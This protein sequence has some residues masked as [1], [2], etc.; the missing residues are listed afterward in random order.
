[1]V[2]TFLIIEPLLSRIL[3]GLLLVMGLVIIR[4]ILRSKSLSSGQRNVKVILNT[5]LFL[6][7]ILFLFQPGWPE[8]RDGEP[9]LVHDT[10]IP[11]EV[12]D[13]VQTA[14]K[15]KRLVSY[16]E[17]R[18]KFREYPDHRLLFFG[19]QAEPQLLSNLAGKEVQW[20]PYFAQD[21]L[22]ELE[23]QGVL[24]KGEKQTVTGKISLSRPGKI[25]LVYGG[26]TLD[27]L[28]LEK[29]FN[30]FRLSFPVFAEG[31]NTVSLQI[32]DQPLQ[33]ITF[34]ARPVQP[35]AITML[36][37][38]PDFES[39]ILAEWL[40]ARGHHVEISTPVAKS[41]L[42]ESFVNKTPARR[43]PDLLIV[44]PS[45]ATDARVRKAVAEGR[46]VLFFG[47]EDVTDALS[48]IN[49]AT[50]TVFSARRT[51]AQESLPLK[52]GLTALPFQLN[53][54][55]NQR[56]VGSLPVHF[57]KNGAKV[58]VSLL[59]E[60]FPARLSGDTLTY[61][62]IWSD[63][64]AALP[65]TDSAKVRVSAPVFKDFPAELTLQTKENH[66]SPDNDTLSLLS[67]LVN[68]VKKSG[69]YTFS[70]TGWKS[71]HQVALHPAGS[72]PVEGH[73]VGIHSAGSS[74]AEDHLISEVYVEDSPLASAV[75]WKSW[76]RANSSLLRS[77]TSPF[78]RP[79]SVGIWFWAFLLCLAALWIEAKFR[80]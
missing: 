57:Q 33:D 2:F 29:G 47:L 26:K 71:L 75:R 21:A 23:W 73:P 37:D 56:Q 27:G 58:A 11:A 13:S 77:E 1:M 72:H 30:A 8:Q 42:Y 5:L 6:L 4:K 28:Q 34:Y 53:P 32:E 64:L 48:R 12:I 52:N 19:Q 25:K 35:M 65:A 39:R 3:S 9:L 80:Y 7:A 67:S 24:R 38:N 79:V 31:R 62:E 41:V 14:R 74:P 78:T 51:S 22:Q 40:G 69:D 49:R 44:A 10:G 55:P 17:F 63:I 61:G 76:R 20:I 66:I 59:N 54:R 70:A 68:P 18:K 46:N 45:Q 36:L 50:G 16:K 60:T 15:I 43:S